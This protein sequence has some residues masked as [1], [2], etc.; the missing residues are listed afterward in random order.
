MKCFDPT[1]WQ[2]DCCGICLRGRAS[3]PSAIARGTERA[4]LLSEG[5]R[6]YAT[7]GGLLGDLCSRLVSGPCAIAGGSRCHVFRKYYQLLNEARR[8]A[9]GTILIADTGG[10][11]AELKKEGRRKRR[12]KTWPLSRHIIRPNRT[13]GAPGEPKPIQRGTPRNSVN[14]VAKKRRN[15]LC[16][17]DNMFRVFRNIFCMFLKSPNLD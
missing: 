16:I 8:Q 17:F 1:R 6:S 11:K 4:Y 7:A 3:R 2:V 15:A 10:K 14:Q 12:V 9:F 13:K 5:L